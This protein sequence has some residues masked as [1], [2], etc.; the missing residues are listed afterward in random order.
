MEYQYFHTSRFEDDGNYTTIDKFIAKYTKL[1]LNKT[2]Y[3]NFMNNFYED[4][5]N[6][7]NITIIK[8]NRLFYIKYYIYFG[9]LDPIQKA[10]FDINV[11]ANNIG[12]T[13][14]T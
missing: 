7:F 1:K 4:L 10:K 8:K 5:K 12:A 6:N 3:N 11:I 2:Q 9:L 13:I 14:H